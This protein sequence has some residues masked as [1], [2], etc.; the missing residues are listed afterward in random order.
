[1]IATTPPHTPVLPGPLAALAPFLSHYGYLAVGLLVLLDNAAIPVPGQTVLILAAVY[2]GAGQLNLAAVIVVAVVAAVA[3]GCVGY[4]LGHYG[5]QALVHRY[6]R[7]VGLTGARLHKAEDFFERNGGKVV[8]V[9]RFIDGLRQTFG[10][11]AGTTGMP[12]RRFLLWNTLGALLWVGVWSTA[13]Y[14]AGSNIDQVY[15][16]AL[17]YQLYL[18]L[19]VAALLL[20][21][22]ARHAL[23]WYERRRRR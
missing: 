18:L 23:R 7:Y 6:G 14:L 15:R 20:A 11:I 2:A 9:A 17:R 1:M 10:I 13:G 22:G 16:T 8:L 19:A 21:L 5:G 4:L 12:W 3:G